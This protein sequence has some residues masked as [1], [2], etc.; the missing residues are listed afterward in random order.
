MTSAQPLRGLRV[1]DFAWIGAGALVTKALAELGADIIRVES[2]ARPDNLRMAPPF[3][4]G[5]EGLEAS[6]YFASRNPGKRSIALNMKHPDARDI[7]LALAAKCDVFTS[8]FRPGVLERWGMAYDDIAAVNPAVV[9]LV[10][11]MQGL[12]GPHKNFIGF[13]S[14]IAALA[15]LVHPSGM[16]DRMPVGTGTHYPDHVP[17]PGHA[18]VALLAAIYHQRR[19]GQ[20][21]MVELSQL[22]STLNVLGPGILQG[23]LGITPEAVGN[24][25]PGVAPRGTYRCHDGLWMA[26][27]CHTET[28]WQALAEVLERKDWLVDARFAAFGDRS[29]NSEALDSEISLAVV[30]HDRA[31]VLGRLTAAGVPAERVSDSRD[32]LEDARLNARGFWED[33]D[34]PVIGEMPMFHIPFRYSGSSRPPMTR[35]PLLGEQTREIAAELLGMTDDEIDRLVD[36][37]VFH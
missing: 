37:G 16:P 9:F 4:P 14:T 17:N 18:L 36:E 25:H 33:I 5:T 21:Q 28:Q 29:R 26:I 32:V 31:D 15:G 7:A 34:H 1:L 35:P 20:G 11:P 10:M 12:D 8:N 23:A 27:A 6:G 24:H 19:T 22:E 2:H 13:G 30:A 3:R